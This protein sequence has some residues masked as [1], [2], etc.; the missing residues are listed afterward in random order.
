MTT[1]VFPQDA[2]DWD[3]A[4]NNGLAT[5][6]FSNDPMKHEFWAHHE[7]LASESQDGAIVADWFRQQTT[8]KFVCIP[9][10]EKDTEL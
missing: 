1:L 9:R 2:L 5:G 8:K 4:F 7:L 10:E 3:A 6:K